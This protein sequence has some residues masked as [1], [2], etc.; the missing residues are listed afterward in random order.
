[1][2]K[3]LI[4]LATGVVLCGLIVVVLAFAAIRVGSR[5]PA[6][7]D[8][9]TLV[10][11]LE[12]EIPEKAP[13]EVPIP[14]FESQ[15]PLTVADVW[16]TLRKAA[17]DP[18]I[19]AVLFE[20]QNLDI[21][22]ARMQELHEELARFRR[23][24]KPL[25]A[26]LRTPGTREY[27]LATAADRIYMM[28]ED[29]LDLK[30][31]RAEVMYFKGTLDKLGVQADVVHAGRYKD[32]GDMF[33]MTSMT[34]ET[35]EVL[36]DVLDQFYG[37]LSNTIADGRHKTPAQV[38]AIIDRGPFNGAT[39]L[40]E[41]LIDVSGFE[42]TVVGDLKKRLNQSELTELALRAYAKSPA[43][44]GVEG[45]ARI[46]LV[47][48]EG[49]ITRGEDETSWSGDETGITS[50]GFTKLLRQVE[51]DSSIRG[52]I[53]RI[54]SPGGDGIA[55]DDILHAAQELGRKKPVV[56]SMGDLAASGGYFIA[57]TGDPIVAY[58]NTLTGSIGV[59]FI[60][61]NLHGLLDKIGVSVDT[62]QRGQFAGLYSTWTSPSPA[63][64]DKLRA[65][66]DEFYHAFVSRVSAGRKKPYDTIEPLAQGRVWMGAQAKGN[67]L[68]DELG[69]LDRAIELVKQK[70]QI[71][72]QENITLV[73]YPP[74]R[75]LFEVLMNRQEESPAISG[76]IRTRLRAIF[77]DLPVDALFHGGFLKVMPFSVT[78]H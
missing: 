34:P 38:R 12:G 5:P 4:G 14:F 67:G 76:A 51:D 52:A 36:N 22:W 23:S 53:I 48:G 19:R 33:T 31:L 45:H 28:P 55:S 11:K 46:A 50:G 64:Q 37:D 40:S 27:Y 9:S 39:A 13:T 60:K 3:F 7:A 78:V 1:M 6:V 21:G 43:P 30:G 42:D 70:A 17:A 35:R 32:Y 71:G 18:R 16:L 69:G 26:L 47:V 58:P 15:S 75:S 65:Q 49:E 61:P 62:M 73:P 72:A 56:I 59:V 66:V 68:V 29:M 20:P 44:S 25:V 10:M 77:G 57:Q 24:G 2:K 8:G 63:E 41:G 74:R 54:N